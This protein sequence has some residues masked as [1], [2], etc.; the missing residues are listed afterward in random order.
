[1]TSDDLGRTWK[2]TAGQPELHDQVSVAGAG[3]RHVWVLAVQEE[4]R[5]AQLFTTGDGGVAWQRQ[6]LPTQVGGCT[7]LVLAVSSDQKLWLLCGDGLATAMQPKWLYASIDSGASWNLV[8]SADVAAES[9]GRL[10]ISGHIFDSRGFAV[11]SPTTAFMALNRGTLY[12]TR[13]GGKNWNDVVTD[14]PVNLGDAAIGP[15]HFIDTAHGWLVSA[16][17]V[18]RTTDGGITWQ[19]ST[20]N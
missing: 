13:D 17:R 16:G 5:L 18:F 7:S 10:P 3:A 6:L 1:M 19:I 4:S 12:V 15:L 9:I 8:S 14:Q 20:I 11:T 2:P